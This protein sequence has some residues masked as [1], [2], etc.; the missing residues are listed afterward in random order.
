MKI[1]LLKNMICTA[2]CLAGLC[3]GTLRASDDEISVVG[4]ASANSEATATDQDAA[5]RDEYEHEI[6]QF[7]DALAESAAQLQDAEWNLNEED[8]PFSLTAFQPGSSMSG[9][10]GSTSR[11]PS[12]SSSRSQRFGT[13]GQSNS[14]AFNRP[15][16]MIADNPGGGGSPV[17]FMFDKPGVENILGLQ[18][19][20]DQPSFSFGRTNISEN[21]SPLVTDRVYFSY[22]HFHNSSELSLFPNT[23]QGGTSSLNIDRFT[24][25]AEKTLGEQHSIE[26]RA[27][28]NSQLNSNLNFSLSPTATNLPFK[29]YNN[30]FGNLSAIIKGNYFRTETFLFA[31]GAALT[32]PTAPDIAVNGRVNFQNL[33]VNDPNGVNAPIF[34]D[35]NLRLNAYLQNQ[36]FLLTPFV[37]YLHT[38]NER[39]FTQG[40]LQFDVPL[41]E[42]NARVSYDTRIDAGV[43]VFDP[44]PV[45]ASGRVSPQTIMRVD[46]GIGYWFI[47]EPDAPYLNQM[48]IMFEAHYTG[49]LTNSE[50]FGPTQNFPGLGQY[51]PVQLTF[52]NGGNR[53]DNLNLVAGIPTRIGQTTFTHG[54]I[55][56]VRNGFDRAFDFEY[57]FFVNRRF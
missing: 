39:I 5:S 42:S 28:M 47:N 35:Y 36:S 15:T 7:P 53:F 18:V 52:G 49:S 44:P 26:F 37:A 1:S 33:Q 3:A 4:N 2:S 43:A 29:D 41:N 19:N 57:S 38:P 17:S 50:V 30:E 51:Q 54:F 20:L 12:S 31:A 46:W 21:N 13:A 55:V 45:D 48:G 9:G 23:P 6:S 16:Y 24:L 25:G 22:R 40:F 56:P 27:P 8:S 14:I 10:G 34:V 32:A 11:P